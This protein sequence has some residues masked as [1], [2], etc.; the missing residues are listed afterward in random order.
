MHGNEVLDYS[1][2]RYPLHRLIILERIVRENFIQSILHLLEIL[3]Q[4]YL[5]H[6]HDAEFRKLID[7]IVCV[8]G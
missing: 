3:F 2:V 4:A 7:P 6:F 8:F 5:S 1:K